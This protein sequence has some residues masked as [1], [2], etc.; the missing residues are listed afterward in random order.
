[1]LQYLGG[2]KTK[3]GQY[4]HQVSSFVDV[5]VVDEIELNHLSAEG[6]D[7]GLVCTD[8]RYLKGEGLST[9]DIKGVMTVS[10]VYHIPPGKLDVRVGGNGPLS[11]RFDEVAPVR[12]DNPSPLAVGSGVSLAMLVA[13]T[14][15]E[16]IVSFLQAFVF[17]A[18]IC[19]YL[20]DMI[21]LDHH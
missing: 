18:L 12:G 10:G 16:F 14:A 6:A 15:L 19:V 17:A 9:S 4:R 2:G 13:L 21:N 3:L 7:P 8:E 1:M 20:S 11:L 5:L